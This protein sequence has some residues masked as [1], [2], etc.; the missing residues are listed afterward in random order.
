MIRTTHLDESGTHDQSPI[1]VMAGYLG[2]ATQWQ[3]FETDWT[4]LLRKAGVPHIHA[5]EPFKRTK[6]RVGK[7]GR[8]MPLL[9]H[10]IA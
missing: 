7:P 2:T 4:A 6:Q 3:R 1:S 8:L 10:W 9:L 5:V